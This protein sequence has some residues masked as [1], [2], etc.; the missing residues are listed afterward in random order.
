MRN[1]LFLCFL[2]GLALQLQAQMDEQATAFIHVNVLPMTST[3]VMKDYTVIVKNRKIQEVGPFSL[4]KVG[5]KIKVIDCQ[6]KYLIPGLTEMHAHIPTPD[7]GD[8]SYAK[9]VLFLYLS[10]GVTTI[11]GM[12]GDPSHLVL[13]KYAAENQML[14]PRIFTATPSFSGGSVPTPEEARE[15]VTTYKKQGYDFLKI[16][17]GL[18]IAVFDA[19]VKTAKKVGIRFSGHVPAEVGIRHALAS[20]YASIDHIDGYLEGLVSDEWKKQNPDGGFFGMSYVPKMDEKEIPALVAETKKQGVW[21]V[22][23]QSLFLRWFSPFDGNALANEPEMQY[24]PS[25]T[26][27]QWRQSKQQLTGTNFSADQWR[28]YIDLRN[29]FLRAMEQSE[30]NL[31]LGSD[32]PQ[33]FNV[34]G[35]SLRHEMKGLQDAGL[36]AFT[37]LQSGTANPARFFGKTGKFGTIEKGASADL[38]LLGGNPLENLSNIWLQ[39]GVMVRGKWLSKEFIAAELAKIAEKHK[40]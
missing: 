9:E 33:V 22:P 8:D 28:I 13:R 2:F 21:I 37:I 12:L 18:K 27:Y 26:L 31:L 5:A 7:K 10:N 38:I 30:V 11:R 6:G 16:H 4:V 34:P 20:K 39:E 35:F 40:S 3:A 19:M 15:K 25:K 23:T 36:S 17:P 14:S 24:M 29:K 1:C 32:A